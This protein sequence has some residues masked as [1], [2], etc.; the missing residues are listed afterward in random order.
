MIKNPKLAEDSM[1]VPHIRFDGNSK[2]LDDVTINGK[3]QNWNHRQIDAHGLFLL[4]LNDA[5]NRSLVRKKDLSKKRL[6]V[7]SKFP[8]FFSAI[9][10]WDYE[11]SGAWEE[12]ERKNTSSIAVVSQALYRLSLW[13]K[14]KKTVFKTLNSWRKKQGEEWRTK[15]LRKL[16]TK[17]LKTVKYQ[18]KLGGESP[19][20]KNTSSP[21]FRLADVALMN[22]I[23][24]E[25]LH[26]LTEKDYR[27]VVDIIENLKRPAGILRYENDSYQSGNYWIKDP[28]SKAKTI[29]ISANSSSADNFAKRFST[30]MPNTEAQWFFDSK[31]SWIRIE[32]SKMSKDPAQIRIDKKLAA[33]HL[34]R[35][36]GQITGKNQISA[37]GKA[38]AEML[39]PESINTV[40]IDG[41]HYYLA[42]PITPLNWAKA[43]LRIAIEK[44]SE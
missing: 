16:H 29:K 18:L 13:S 12:I 21:K 17:G 7:L 40:V 35:A 1:A 33:T 23:I 8:K 27:H 10:Y 38:V 44:N 32:L 15:N 19:D 11:D 41:K 2:N 42:S 36:V 6:T 14:S 4:A 5:L 26:G 28:N 25:P 43:G 9:K 39:V 20:Y 24:P 37:D 3:V 30:L 31:L 34:K 22:V